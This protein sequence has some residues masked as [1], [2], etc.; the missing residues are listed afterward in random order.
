M[1]PQDIYEE[2]RKFFQIAGTGQS[3]TEAQ[4]GILDGRI[5]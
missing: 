4:C 1:T 2:V 3:D 5:F